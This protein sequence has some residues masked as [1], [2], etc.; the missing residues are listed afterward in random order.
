M[1]LGNRQNLDVVMGR[2][3]Q[4]VGGNRFLKLFVKTMPV[5]NGMR[6]MG[7]NLQPKIMKSN[8]DGEDVEIMW[9]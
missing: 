1:L 6:P 5:G 3:F 4:G 8:G 7:H 2:F 9:S